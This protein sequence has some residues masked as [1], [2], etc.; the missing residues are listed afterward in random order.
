[1]SQTKR[2]YEH[3]ENTRKRYINQLEYSKLIKRIEQLEKELYGEEYK[4]E[5]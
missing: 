1:M 4:K 3:T 2:Y 5:D